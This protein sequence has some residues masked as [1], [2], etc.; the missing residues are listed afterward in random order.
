LVQVVPGETSVY[1]LTLH[2][3]GPAP[4]T[5]IVLTDVLPPGL[6]PLWTQPSHPVCE[7]RGRSVS[8]HA[9][10]SLAGDEITVTLDLSVGGSDSSTAGI[11]LAGVKWGLSGPA[12]AIDRGATSSQVECRMDNLQ[13]GGEAVVSFGVGVDA[14]A[15]G[16][17]VHTA[18]VVAH[19]A[20]TNESNDRATFT[21]TLGAEGPV[22]SEPVSG[23]TAPLA[24]DLV[25]QA[26]GPASV[27]A[28]QPFTYT[29]TITNRGTVDATGVRF[30]HPVPPATTLGAYAPAPPLCRQ[31]DDELL[32]TLRDVDSG[33]TVTFTLVITGH[34]GQRMEMGLD[35]LMPGWP[36]C[37]LLKEKP[38]LHILN[39]DLGTLKPDQATAV[40]SALTAIGVNERTMTSTASVSANKADPNPL[41][42]TITNTIAVQISADVLVRV[43][44]PGPAVA[45]EML[46]Y[47]LTAVNLGPS[48][49]DVVLTDTLPVGTR[50]VSAASSRGDD[51]HAE[52]QEPAAD[53]VV[54]NLGRLGRGE[55]A[56]VDVVVVVDESL[57]TLEE[58]VH[59]ARVVSEQPD[60]R[61]GNNELTQLIPVSAGVDD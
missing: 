37:T 7:R 61:L 23:V 1:T 16:A 18:S 25:L 19:E 27:V 53:A 34:A 22:S 45:G 43:A 57:T 56:A 29:Y 59:S 54:C 31:R 42:N 36:I 44:P 12:C 41:D 46:S 30:H 38:W 10:D 3:H 26:D 4:A 39:C 48:D 20:D 28:G 8:C 14:G 6:I 33:E 58:I 15:S 51:C 47:T 17:L 11:E 50:F 49:A 21:V 35:P 2:N 55:T 32:C 24:T 13:P 60:P 9:P 52:R 40:R 5:G